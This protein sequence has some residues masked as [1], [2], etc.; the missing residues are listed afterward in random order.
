MNSDGFDRYHFRDNHQKGFCEEDINAILEIMGEDERIDKFIESELTDLVRGAM[1]ADRVGISFENNLLY[2]IEFE[3]TKPS[4]KALR[5]HALYVAAIGEI[6]EEPIKAIS[7][8]ISE[9]EKRVDVVDYGLGSKIKINVKPYY[10][11]DGEEQLE[12]I[13]NKLKN[14]E[15]I[16][17][18]DIIF[19]SIGFD[20]KFSREKREI[21]EDFIAIIN[22]IHRDNLVSNQYLLDNLMMRTVFECE[23]TF[24]EDECEEILEGFDMELVSRD[25]VINFAKNEGR[26]EGKKEGFEEV[27]KNLLV[28]NV[29]LNTIINCTGLTKNEIMELKKTI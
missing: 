22:N 9:S 17:R 10:S 11:I 5:K 28:E 15:N 7:F 21:F 3:S 20:A 23:N 13:K 1:V 16:N 12:I 19:L 6:H 27:A 25:Y 14:N 29:D 26:K 8:T 24:D 4:K 18:L 2:S